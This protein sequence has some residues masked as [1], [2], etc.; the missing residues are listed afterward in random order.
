MIRKQAMRTQLIIH[1]LAQTWKKFTIIFP[2]IYF[3]ISD[4][5]YIKTSKSFKTF[6]G[7]ENFQFFHVMNVKSL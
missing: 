1:T 3:M 7:H 2:I 4:G 6:G 5:G